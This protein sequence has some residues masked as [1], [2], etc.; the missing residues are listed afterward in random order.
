M[1][2]PAQRLPVPIDG[3]AP[4]VEHAEDRDGRRGCRR[5]P[6]RRLGVAS[7]GVAEALGGSAPGAGEHGRA[8]SER[9]LWTSVRTHRG[10]SGQAGRNA[11]TLEPRLDLAH[12]PRWRPRRACRRRGAGDR[13]R[14]QTAMRPTPR[15]KT[16]RISSVEICP[17][18]CSV[19]NSGGSSQ[20]AGS[21][22][23]SQSCRQYPH[24]V[25]GDAAAG[26]VG[27]AVHPAEH[28][29]SRRPQ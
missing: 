15:L 28:R 18:C 8:T 26:D 9:R 25:P 16:S 3:I 12:R 14:R 6:R 22:T 2:E 7:A 4:A 1:P 10:F 29:A 11:P 17:A 21:T 23:A 24:Q 5:P 19:A 20:D 27:Q 13:L